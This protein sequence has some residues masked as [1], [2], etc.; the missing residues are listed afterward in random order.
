MAGWDEKQK[1]TSLSADPTSTRRTTMDTKAVVSADAGVKKAPGAKLIRYSDLPDPIPGGFEKEGFAE[2]LRN[3]KGSR[4]VREFSL[5]TDLSDSFISKAIN[6]YIDKPPSKRTLLKL[7][8]AKGIA[9]ADRRELVRKAGYPEDKLDWEHENW[10][11]DDR[12]K[13]STAETIA[14]FYG[15][16]HFLACGRL[17]KG[18]AEHGVT[19]DM[20]S[21]ICREDGYFEIKDETTGQV[22]VGINVYCNADTDKDNAVWSLVFSL[23]LTFNKVA[24]SKDAGDKVVIIMTNNEEIFEGCQTI[25]FG[26]VPKA[27]MVVLTDDYKGF[28]KEEVLSGKSPISLLD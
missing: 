5:E 26:D 27:T 7:L 17:M 18:L 8:C 13:V 21:Y 15:G 22:Y 24:Q 25:G 16:N 9:S 19:G 11:D 10:N 2:V 28:R 4:S 12:Q 23:A 3:M 20:S 14:R 1:A 6:G